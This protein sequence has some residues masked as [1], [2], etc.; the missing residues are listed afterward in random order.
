MNGTEDEDTKEVLKFIKKSLNK[1]F[2]FV[3]VFLP[4]QTNVQ[5][6]IMT[7]KESIKRTKDPYIA[8]HCGLTQSS[9]LTLS[10]ELQHRLQE[11][12]RDMSG[13]AN[14][15]DLPMDDICAGL[16]LFEYFHR[17]INTQDTRDTM[18][19]MIQ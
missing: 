15:H 7:I 18:Q 11:L 4:L 19:G 8:H 14:G 17:Y 9:R 6:L 5:D 13:I 16:Q 2:P 10:G 3:N 1:G 12:Q